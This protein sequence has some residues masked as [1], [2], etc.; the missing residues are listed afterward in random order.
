MNNR[1]IKKYPNVFKLG[2]E[3]R[4]RVVVDLNGGVNEVIKKKD[5][6]EKRLLATGGGGGGELR[7]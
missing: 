4:I 1:N 5:S 3:T 6:Q 7:T 2:V